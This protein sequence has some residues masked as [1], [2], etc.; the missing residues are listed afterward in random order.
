MEL[1]DLAFRANDL[2]EAEEAFAAARALSPADERPAYNLGTVLLARGKYP[3]AIDLLRPLS[4]REDP[5]DAVVFNLAEAY[6]ATGALESARDLL[7]SLV[8]RQPSFEG[9]SFALGVT[10]DALGDLAGAETAY[11]AALDQ[12]GDD[13]ACLLNL[14]SVLERL[15]HIDEARVLLEKAIELPMEEETARA[16]QEAIRALGPEG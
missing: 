6:R 3:E 4:E 7:R 8:A 12:N 9:A 13:L 5:Q 15:D 2:A 10:L 11:R 16:I 14:A 1:G